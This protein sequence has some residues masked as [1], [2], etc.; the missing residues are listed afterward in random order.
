MP[1]LSGRLIAGHPDDGCRKYLSKAGQNLQDCMAYDPTKRR[2]S[3]FYWIKL[4]ERET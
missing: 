1:P 4:N 3:R 2:V